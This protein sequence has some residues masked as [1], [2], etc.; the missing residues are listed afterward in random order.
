MARVIR[1]AAHVVRANASHDHVQRALITG[2]ADLAK[3]RA[4]LRESA[5]R[6]IGTLALEVASRVVGEQVAVDA[7]LL[8]RIVARALSRARADSAVRV[9]LHPDDRAL[10]EARTGEAS[11]DIVL[12]DDPTQAR[13]GC[14]VRGALV[15]VEARVATGIAALARAMGVEHPT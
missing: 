4:R 1:G 11:P 12:V 3:E 2:M 15:T 5:A 14:L 9:M 7:A 10:I 8:E 13:G 6:E